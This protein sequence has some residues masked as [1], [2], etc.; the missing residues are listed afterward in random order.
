MRKE[1]IYDD[2]EGGLLSRDRPQPFYQI[3]PIYDS[4][5]KA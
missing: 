4:K 2:M 1:I 3:V 5:L